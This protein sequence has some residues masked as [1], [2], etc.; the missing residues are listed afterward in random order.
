MADP[1]GTG[2]G[3]RAQLALDETIRASG[4][5]LQPGLR[6]GRYVLERELGHGG[7]GIVWL[8][9]DC[10]LGD[11][12]VALKFLPWLL[13][14]DAL[15]MSHLRRE[16]RAMLELSHPGIVRLH[17]LERHEDTLFL[18]M[19]Y[20]A[21]PTLHDVLA[22]RVEKNGAGLAVTEVTWLLGQMAPAL[23]YAH[24]RGVLH[25]D[26]KP[27][28]LMLA[29]RPEGLLDRAGQDVKLCD[30]GIAWVT[31]TSVSQLTGAQPKAGTQLYMA[32]EVLRGERP[33]VVSDVYAL[34]VTLFV[35]V[36]GE[37]PFV[38]GDLVGQIANRPAPALAS[39]DARLDAAVASALEKDPAR[40]PAGAGAMLAAVMG[41]VQA[42]TVP[43]PTAAAQ[44]VAATPNLTWDVI[45]KSVPS[46]GSI[47]VIH[48]LRN[49]AG[50]Q[51]HEAKQV[52]ESLPAVVLKDA[53]RKEA[54]R[55][56][57]RLEAAG[58]VVSL[59]GFDA[60]EEEE[61]QEPPEEP[62]AGPR[63]REGV[64]ARKWIATVRNNLELDVRRGDPLAKMTA[65]LLDEAGDD[66][67]AAHKAFSAYLA[68]KKARQG[69]QAR[70]AE[71]PAAAGCPTCRAPVGARDRQCPKCQSLL[72][73]NASCPRCGHRHHAPYS[74]CPRCGLDAKV[75]VECMAAVMEAYQQ[76]VALAGRSLGK[77]PMAF[78]FGEE[79]RKHSGN[80]L[81]LARFEELPTI[82]R[83]HAAFAGIAKPN[84][85][86]V[87]GW[88][89]FWV[90]AAGL[91]GVFVEFN[92]VALY[93]AAGIQ[94]VG[95]LLLGLVSAPW[96]RSRARKFVRLVDE[97]W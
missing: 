3:R 67:E 71:A 53:A 27:A 64:P 90:S 2:A 35:L 9:R 87:L 32:P 60:E 63:A 57:R 85:A 8:G 56:C 21:G 26:I 31:N 59:V 78:A 84:L 36:R 16:A 50:L 23:D 29:G 51:L 93:A 72:L 76:A 66:F 61:E 86:S 30:F 46:D 14:Q 43:V 94:L 7:M 52:V 11:R 82:A 38:H 73:A 89:C 18:A 95:W 34:G 80:L 54:E 41:G 45:L 39:G 17:N 13:A 44:R 74:A 55:L 68:E 81:A 62:A 69:E 75:S 42:T 25:R 65:R 79:A 88:I 40:R 6:L 48:E 37:P 91:V 15:A 97:L 58:A 24:S 20:L 1:T 77:W 70:E 49:H 19:E 5:P 47:P 83:L 22:D 92:S 33:S 12:P 4:S 28:N 10:E 96:R